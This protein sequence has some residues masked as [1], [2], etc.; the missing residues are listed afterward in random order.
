MKRKDKGRMARV[1][2]DCA[3]RKRKGFGEKMGGLVDI[4][5]AKE[6]R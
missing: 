6:M 2:T 3:L 5:G 1:V 4:T